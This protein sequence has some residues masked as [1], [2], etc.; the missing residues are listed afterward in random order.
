MGGLGMME[1]LLILVVVVI[2]FGLGKLPKALGDVGRGV[3]AFKTG[4]REAQEEAAREEAKKAVLTAQEP[5]QPPK[6]TIN[7]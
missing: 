3:G 4:L 2:L 6:D 1:I 5:V 7:N